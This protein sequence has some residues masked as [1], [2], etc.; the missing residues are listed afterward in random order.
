MQRPSW[1]Q[2]SR[3]CGRT[4]VARCSIALAILLA[5]AASGCESCRAKPKFD[6]PGSSKAPAAPEP[7]IL[8]G[9]VK[10]AP[11]F[12][13]PVYTPDEMER[14]VLQ[15]IHGG[16]FPETCTPPK[17]S[18]RTPVMQAPDG[19][20]IGVM[21][22]AS[23]FSNGTPRGPKV[24]DVVIKDCRLTP[25]LVVG[26]LGDL[27]N[28][29]NE[30]QFPFMPT[31]GANAYNETLTP[32]QSK[33]MRLD[34]AGVENV[35]C[36][37]TAP[38]GRTDVVVVRHP[39]FSVTDDKGMFK[40]EDFPADETVQVN[41]WH[42]LFQDAT[43]SVKVGKGETKSVEFVLTPLPQKAAEPAAEPTPEEPKPEVPAKAGKPK[44][45]K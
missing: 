12:E 6:S 15:H 17:L 7:A 31:Y 26:Q 19:K 24:F 33:A 32:G 4:G 1:P 13:L 36:G 5:L 18:D 11:G 34:K 44:A 23:Q 40:I 38:C 45:A 9:S 43:I 28:L 29:K 3:A 20:L 27:I 2:A 35:M 25:R 41:A 8:T 22:A 39:V 10:L 21:V 16:T 42:P 14:K 37:F 30:V